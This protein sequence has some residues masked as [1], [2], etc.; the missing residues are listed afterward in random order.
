MRTFRCIYINC[1]NSL[2]FFADISK[3]LQKGH[4]FWQFKDPNSGSRYENNTNNSIFSSAFWALTVQ[5][6]HFCIWKLSKFIF[7]GS[8]FWGESCDIRILSRSIQENTHRGKWKTNTFSI[9][10]RINSKTSRIISWSKVA[11]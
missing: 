8:V 6:P 4:S 11:E 3:K 1:Y 5:E 7:I 9:E 2:R 10:L